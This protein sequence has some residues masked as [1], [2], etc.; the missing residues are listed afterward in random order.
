VDPLTFRRINQGI[1]MNTMRKWVATAAGAVALVLGTSFAAVQAQP[2]QIASQP[3]NLNSTADRM[4][5]YRHQYHMW[6]T[7]DGATHVLMN[8]GVTLNGTALALQTS[9]DGQTWSIGALMQSTDLT[10][11]SDGALVGNDLWVSY[12]NNVGQLFLT[13]LH[14]DASNH[15]WSQVATETVFNAAGT[16]ASI[17]SMAFDPS[18]TLWLAFTAQDKATGNFSIKLLRKPAGG[19]WV[20]TGMVF[21]PVDNSAGSGKPE[22]SARLLAFKDQVSMVYTVHQNVFWASRKN[23]WDPATAWPSTQ[24][25]VDQVADTDPWGS[26]FSTAVDTLGNVHLAMV[27]GGKLVYGR[28]IYANQAWIAPRTMTNDIKA[29]YEQVT[30]ANGS[31]VVACN[32]GSVLRVFQSNDGG[33]S[34]ANTYLLVHPSPTGTISYDRP[35]IEAP[36]YSAG[37]IPLLQQYTDG[38]QSQF[39]HAMYFSVPVNAPAP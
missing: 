18:G 20:D 23:T 22:R 27:D 14:Y 15:L 13:Q 34:F 11:T 37:P 6:Q 30:I 7:A 12:S 19:A 4:L 28:F 1:T 29:T 33:A 31:I 26:H 3:T 5:S 24:I 16:L 32:A 8:R 17:P 10:T 38:A 21:G 25:Y 36:A 39:Q 35:R 9:F 2:V